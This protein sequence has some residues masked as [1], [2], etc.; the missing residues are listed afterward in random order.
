M[1]FDLEPKSRREDLYDFEAELRN[2]VNGIINDR[3]TVI[4]GGLR[5]TGKTSLMRIALNEVGYPYIYLDVRFTGRPRQADLI[6]LIRRGLEDFLARNKPII[7]RIRDALSRIRWVRIGASPMHVEIKLGEFRRLSIGELLNAINDL[8]TELGKPVIIAIDEAQEL[9]RVTWIDFNALLAY[10]Y[11]NLKYVKFL[12]S[13][14]EVGV[15]DKF[16]RVNDPEAPLFG[17]Y[18]HFVSTGR[19]SP[20]ESLDFLRRGGFEQYGGVRFSDELLMRIVNELDGVIG[21]LTYIGHQYVVEG[22]QSLDE[23]L[24][25]ATAWHLMNLGTS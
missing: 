25:S 10:S 22:R 24:E 7:D 2:L 4:R 12:I 5:R 1:L 21:W 14:S 23:V 18:M 11:D 17:R 13:C 9:S 20:D 8:G 3:I 19:L 6:E 15:L 16:L